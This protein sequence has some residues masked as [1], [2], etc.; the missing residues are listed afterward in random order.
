MTAGSYA[1]LLAPT[2]SFL[3][4][5]NLSQHGVEQYE[6][7]SGSGDGFHQVSLIINFPSRFAMLSVPDPQ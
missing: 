2:R 5:S 3:T 7:I 6:D 1:Q 4:V